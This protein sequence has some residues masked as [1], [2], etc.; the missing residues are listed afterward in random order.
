MAGEQT[1]EPV[2]DRSKAEDQERTPERGQARKARLRLAILTGATVGAVVV[3]TLN[4]E[5]GTTSV[6][7]NMNIG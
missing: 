5:P 3:A 6:S 4:A 7:I 2:D 1:N